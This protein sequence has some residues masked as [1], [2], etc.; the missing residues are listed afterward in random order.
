MHLGL[1]TRV[2]HVVRREGVGF[3]SVCEVLV[4]HLSPVLGAFLFKRSIFQV[5]I[6]T[7]F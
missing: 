3:S 5:H 6:V 2:A 4:V 1:E 7:M